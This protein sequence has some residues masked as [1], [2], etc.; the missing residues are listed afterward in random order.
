MVNDAQISLVLTTTKTWPR[1]VKK[2][3]MGISEKQ[4]KDEQAHTRPK[5]ERQTGLS[6]F[7]FFPLSE[8]LCCRV[9]L[10]R[11]GGHRQTTTEG[12]PSSFVLQRTAVVVEVV[13]AP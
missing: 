3:V 1:M 5:P 11:S 10:I 7:L 4:S 9:R 2:K 12:L 13:A 8:F 6:S